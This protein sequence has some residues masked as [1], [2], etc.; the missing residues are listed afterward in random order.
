VH[1]TITNVIGHFC[2]VNERDSNYELYTIFHALHFPQSSSIN[3]FAVYFANEA[4]KF[5][6]VSHDTNKYHA[7]LFHRSDSFGKLVIP[8]FARSTPSSSNIY[9]FKYLTMSLLRRSKSPPPHPSS[10]LP[11]G[12][13]HLLSSGC[14]YCRK[15][16]LTPPAFSPSGNFHGTFAAES[17]ALTRHIRIRPII[18]F[19]K[20]TQVWVLCWQRIDIN[21][22]ILA[23]RR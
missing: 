8:S 10:S 21:N 22:D 4:V 5:K 17:Q 6:M 13:P 1:S 19:T 12:F 16:V 9:S 23:I 14:F 7:S 11:W 20:C 15:E 18:C 2:S 3:K